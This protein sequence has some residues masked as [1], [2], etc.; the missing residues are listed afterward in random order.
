[1]IN[2]QTK[3][4]WYGI[5]AL[6]EIIDEKFP[7]A[8]TIAQI[9]LFKWTLKKMYKLISYNRKVI[10]AIKPGTGY[11]CS[12]DFNVSYRILLLIIG[13]I[14][15]TLMLYPYEKSIFN[16]SFIAE[17]TIEKLQTTHL[18]F[19]AFNVLCALC[20]KIKPALEYL[21]QVNMLALICILLLLPLHILNSFVFVT[22]LLTNAYL[23]VL[24][25][26]M[27]FNYY[28]RMTYADVIPGYPFIVVI[29]LV[30][31]IAF[32]TYLAS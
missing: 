24:S 1:M 27:L 9:P 11:N 8:K 12:P 18:L 19:V 17:S 20:I 4:V 13:F 29:N 10:V 16:N 31:V 25:I 28:R 3:Q 5:D 23:L 15:N 32:I 2:V 7:V 14:F 30:S 6:L 22:P 26:F 21:G